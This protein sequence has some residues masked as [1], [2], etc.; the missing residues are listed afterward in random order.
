MEIKKMLNL[1]TFKM[2]I[3][4]CALAVMGMLATHA[5]VKAVVLVGA[6]LSRISV[7]LTF[8]CNLRF[9]VLPSL[10]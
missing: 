1:N 6:T 2:G 8:N 3:V 9:A 7:E 4:T 5:P 10:Q